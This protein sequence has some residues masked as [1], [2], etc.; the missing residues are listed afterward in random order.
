MRSSPGG[1]DLPRI[2]VTS[3]ERPA[4]LGAGEPG[5]R[6]H[7]E[8]NLVNLALVII[9]SPRA[10][11]NEQEVLPQR[12]YG[13]LVTQADA[14]RGQV[15]F[16]IV[17]NKRPPAIAATMTKSTFTYDWPLEST[18]RR[19]SPKASSRSLTAD[20]RRQLNCVS[21]YR[22]PDQAAADP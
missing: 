13:R 17:D 1:E 12:F 6:V 15:Q 16:I 20:T 2:N 7:Y 18:V 9:E 10:A 22:C 5:D 4:I 14:S 8:V 11:H 19:L 21:D 3:R